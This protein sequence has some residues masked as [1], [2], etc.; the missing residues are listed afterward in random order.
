MMNSASSTAPVLLMSSAL[1]AS[2][3]L[4]RKGLLDGGSSARL[5]D[6]RQGNGSTLHRRNL[7]SRT[8]LLLGAPGP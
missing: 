2:R 1:L 4:L 5:E 6:H 7:L 3:N 8:E